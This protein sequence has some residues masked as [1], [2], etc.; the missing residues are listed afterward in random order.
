[1]KVD[2]TNLAKALNANKDKMEKIRL[3]VDGRVKFIK[4]GQDADIKTALS[5][6]TVE[7]IAF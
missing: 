1:M 6:L 5:G 7:E 4:D 3:K 2:I